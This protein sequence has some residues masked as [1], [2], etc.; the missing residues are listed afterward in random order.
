MQDEEEVVVLG[1]EQHPRGNGTA[2]EPTIAALLMPTPTP[3]P[4]RAPKRR[5]ASTGAG[6]GRGAVYEADDDDASRAS[7]KGK[8][9][10][11][12]TRGRVLRHQMIARHPYGR[13]D[14]LPHQVI[15]QGGIASSTW[16]RFPCTPDIDP[17][18][19]ASSI[20]LW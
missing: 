15:W 17:T 8:Q 4:A 20:R 12:G 9:V 6:R 13:Q 10:R 5:R 19:H 16:T 14:C 7:S 18:W 2:T 11:C 3:T 1:V